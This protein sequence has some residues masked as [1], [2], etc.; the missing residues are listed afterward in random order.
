[1][2][3]A[4]EKFSTLVLALNTTISKL[5]KSNEIKGGRDELQKKVEGLQKKVD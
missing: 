3:L 1:L 5:E 2:K 4:N